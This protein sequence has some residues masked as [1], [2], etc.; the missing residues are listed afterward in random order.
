IQRYSSDPVDAGCSVHVA[1]GLISPESNPPAVFAVAVCGTRSAFL[2]V[3]ASPGRT[4]R[5]AGTNR[6]FSIS[7]VCWCGSGCAEA[8]YPPS[9]TR[10]PRRT[11]PASDGHV[12]A[13]AQRRLQLF[14]MFQVRYERRADFDEQR[15]QLRVL[16]IGNQDVVQ[17]VDHLLVVGDLVINV[18]LVKGRSLEGAQLGEV[19]V[20][21][22][23]QRPAGVIFLGR[24]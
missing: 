23:F 10:A 1:P 5:V 18:G 2:K 9:P 14:C 24:Q 6:M 21:A 11:R 15:L 22:G 8:R 20:A 13:S 3:T 7:T 12:A 4:W 17:R 19:L 16:R